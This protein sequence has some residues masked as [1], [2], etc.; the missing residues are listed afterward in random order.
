MKH[1]FDTQNK[2][3]EALHRIKKR[4]QDIHDIADEASSN[5]EK[6]NQ[7]ILR[8]DQ[9]IVR[10]DSTMTRTKRY[11]AYFGRGFLRDKVAVTF[12]LLILACVIGIIVVLVLPSKNVKKLLQMPEEESFSFMK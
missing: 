8:I 10:M 3:K 12:L 5:L 9:S 2:S 6:Q 7:Q 11:L 4:V 1:G